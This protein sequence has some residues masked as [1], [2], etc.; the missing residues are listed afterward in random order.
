LGDFGYEAFTTPHLS[1]RS[2]M[3]VLGLVNLPPHPWGSFLLA[4]EKL[5][6]F[7]ERVCEGG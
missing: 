6:F 4:K 1:K 3:P 2:L 5:L 7:I